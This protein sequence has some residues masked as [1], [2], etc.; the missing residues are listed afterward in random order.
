MY[1]EG[2]CGTDACVTGKHA[3][4]HDPVDSKNTSTKCP[5]GARRALRTKPTDGPR[6]LSWGITRT[7]LTA[8]LFNELQGAGRKRRPILANVCI[9]FRRNSDRCCQL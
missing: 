4:S 3:D 7:M 6:E 8:A 5:C 1:A 2:L 9:Q